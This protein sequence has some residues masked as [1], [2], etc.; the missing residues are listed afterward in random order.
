[1]NKETDEVVE[2]LGDT[3]RQEPE[4]LMAARK[5]K[6][7]PRKK[8]ASKTKKATPSAKGAKKKS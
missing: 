1:M 3:L 5:R 2:V 7:A 8:A 6:K 4:G